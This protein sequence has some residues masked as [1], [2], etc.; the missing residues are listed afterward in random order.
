[1][2]K[3][4]PMPGKLETLMLDEVAS[5]PLVSL[6]LTPINLVPEKVLHRSLQ[7]GSSTFG[8]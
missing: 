2:G 5:L 8:F 6:L 7:E 1:M 4:S 3:Q